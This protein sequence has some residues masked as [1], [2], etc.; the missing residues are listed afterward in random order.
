[1]VTQKIYL[2]DV[3]KI[4]GNWK[5]IVQHTHETSGRKTTYKSIADDFFKD[6]QS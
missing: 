6:Q 4:S 2:V 3:F 5:H 1:M